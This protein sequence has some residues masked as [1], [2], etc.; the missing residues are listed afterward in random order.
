MSSPTPTP[1]VIGAAQ[2]IRRRHD[3]L[4]TRIGPIELMVEATEAAAADAGSS[5]LLDRVGWIGVAGGYWSYRNP[6]Q[7]V[8]AAIG[9]PDVASALSRISGSAPIEMLG[10][11]AAA[12]ATG[13]VDV[14]LVVGGEA[15][16][17]SRRVK[18]SGRKP[19]W[20]N[21][22][23]RGSPQIF[24]ASPDDETVHAESRL[25]GSPANTYALMGDAERL[26][27]GLTIDE[28]RDRIS[29]LWARFSEVATNHEYA[30][31][32]TTHRPDAIRTPTEHN[33]MIAFP[34]TKAMVAN[35]D[36][37]MASAIILCSP[38]V[39]GE[40]GISTDGAVFPHIVT[41]AHE[42]WQLV[43]RDHLHLSPALAAAGK[44]AFERVGI[45]PADVEHVDLYSC[46][47]AIVRMNCDAL[48]FDAA[49]PLTVTGGLGFAGAP[50]GNAA[51]QS[52]AAMVPLVRAGGWGV[53]HGNG[54]KATTQ[55]F[56]VL[57]SKPP[58]RFAFEDCQASADLRPRAALPADWAGDV[59][60][61]GATVV[62]DRQGPSHV[63]A[64]V[65]PT[66]DQD[67]ARG[68]AN[69]T[70]RDLI[71]LATTDGLGGVTFSR[72]SDGSLTA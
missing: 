29:E 28:Y 24:A 11:A 16:W 35:N 21:L 49:R 12:I 50:V 27:A 26:A 37:D 15:R 25:L 58:E 72:Q 39:A 62:Y 33:R 47:P 7:L 56:V 57:S 43:N 51:G 2:V 71:E 63:L 22:Q 40:L 70:D 54:G 53:V 41:K 46:F 20:P 61:E 45:T 67:A 42:T 52:M 18:R 64:A 13:D 48:G 38:A 4:A 17:T 10:A 66:G 68:W 34:Y 8:G 69:T 6:A 31:D 19:A 9:R 23:S 44:R 36:V 1:A 3:D 30:W 55:A 60:I 59:S 32:Q 65:R 14:A 5:R